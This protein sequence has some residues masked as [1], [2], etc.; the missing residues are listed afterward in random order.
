MLQ[1]LNSL[2]TTGTGQ[3]SPA[4]LAGNRVFRHQATLANITLVSGG[5]DQWADTDGGPHAASHRGTNRPTF[6]PVG[7]NGYPALVFNNSALGKTSGFPLGSYS[8]VLVH[9]PTSVSA[10][11]NLYSSTATNNTGHAIFNLTD[12]YQWEAWANGTYPL[13]QSRTRIQ[14]NKPEILIQTYDHA[15]GTFELWIN[16]VRAGRTTGQ[17]SLPTAGW[18]YGAF[19]T[20]ATL[21]YTGAISYADTLNRALT[22]QEIADYTEWLKDRYGF[23]KPVFIVSEG[24]S[25]SV[26]GQFG[27]PVTDSWSCQL[28]RG[29]PAAMLCSNIRFGTS[30]HQ[31]T[32]IQSDAATQVDTVLGT[33]SARKVLVV[34]CGRN[35]MADAARTPAQAV[36]DLV[37]YVTGRKATGLYDDIYC[38]TCIPSLNTTLTATLLS[39]NTLLLASQNGG[40]LQTAGCSGV[41]NLN[42]LPEFDADGDYNNT[43]FFN[44]DKVHLT[45]AGLALVANRVKQVIGL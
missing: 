3:W 2:N 39:F 9:K 16:G 29:L 21:T 20:P 4:L 19:N 32:N 10:L 28:N 23:A 8:K 26:G 31:I 36:A 25:L 45:T 5:V 27:V 37:T 6:D 11:S 22:S 35:D 33:T 12:A 7:M 34:W 30:G 41:V 44:A 43:T 40:A 42:T 13:A 38:V 1:G 18:Q 15:T 17:V 14:L 24:D